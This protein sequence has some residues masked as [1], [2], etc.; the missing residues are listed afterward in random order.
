MIKFI[1]KRETETCMI[2]AKDLFEASDSVGADWILF[3]ISK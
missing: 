3:M 2:W 1:F